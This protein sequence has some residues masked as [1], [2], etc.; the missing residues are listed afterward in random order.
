[1][2]VETSMNTRETHND[3]AYIIH[4]KILIIYSEKF[5]TDID[6]AL[7]IGAHV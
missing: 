6:G 3:V 7:V 2:Y 5:L 4:G 1:M